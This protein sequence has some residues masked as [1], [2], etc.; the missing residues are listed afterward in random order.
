[1][2]NADAEDMIVGKWRRQADGASTRTRS[3]W[4]QRG[5]MEL[6]ADMESL[7]ALVDFVLG[8]IRGSNP[9][10]DL[11]QDIRLVLEE[12]FTNIVF[13]A[14]PGSRGSV[15]VACHNRDKGRLYVEFRDTGIPFDPTKFMPSDLNRD[16]AER[17]IGGLGIHLVRQ[18]AGKI[19]YERMGE[20]NVLLIG[21]NTP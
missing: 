2:N 10:P 8:E 20:W 13:H 5:Q 9:P 17:E 18:L 19:Q 16:F 7:D 15:H 14:Y 4:S 11:A 3:D 6:K 1:M 21:F 12:V